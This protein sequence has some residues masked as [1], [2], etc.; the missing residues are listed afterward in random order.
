MAARPRIDPGAIAELTGLADYVLPF[1]IRVACDLG[2]ADHLSEG[3][4]AV[5][6][7]AAATG[8]HPASL[9]RLLRALAA[10]GIFAEV[11]PETFGLTP[12]AA[13]LRGDHPMSL[14]AA[15]PLLPAD[16]RALGRLTGC[17]R[18]GRAAFE[19]LYGEDYWSYLANHPRDG[20]AVDRWMQS[21]NGVHLRTVLPAYDWACAG[22]VVD[23]G[24]GNGAFLAGLLARYRGLHGVLL[25]LPHVVARAGEVLAAAGVADRCEVVAGSFFDAIPPGGGLYLLKTVLPGWPAGR[26]VTILR[27]IRAAM[28]PDSRLVL[29][30]ALIPEGD[31]FDVAKLVDVHTLA[32]T[33]GRHRRPAE[34]SALLDQA[35]L[36]LL[37]TVPT[38]TLTVVEARPGTADRRPG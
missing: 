4:R 10:S 23:V 14:R 12:L 36:E 15:Y 38:P 1:A 11:A 26:A 20:Q 7:L 17:L 2:V 35:G 37:G 21:L 31:G 25:D 18:T 19:S 24:G 8:T 5:A 33:G 16:I 22:S 29:L 9:H 32:V 34:L 13:P 3:P 27:N 6:E 30:E 28:R